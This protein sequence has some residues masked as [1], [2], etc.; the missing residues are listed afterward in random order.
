LSAPSI[1]VTLASLQAKAANAAKARMT[2]FGDCSL[3]IQGAFE[4]RSDHALARLGLHAGDIPQC[5]GKHVRH[6]GTADR[7]LAVEYEERNTIDAH[8]AGGFDLGK[9][10]I[11]VGIRSKQAGDDLAVEARLFGDVEKDGMVSDI[12]ALLEIGLEQGAHDLVLNLAALG[13]RPQDQAVGVKRI[14]ADSGSFEVEI[15]ADLLA[16]FA[17]AIMGLPDGLG[18][19][20]LF[21]E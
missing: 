11:R 5:A 3:C 16:K 12:A 1:I 8:L 14:G 2:P 13:R 20:E 21:S 10:G 17:Q 7:I 6:L 9:H 15:D 4:A 18:A 19:A